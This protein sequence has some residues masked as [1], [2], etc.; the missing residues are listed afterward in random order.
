[1]T[2]TAENHTPPAPGSATRVAIAGLT[3]AGLAHATVLATLPGCEIAGVSDPRTAPRRS[4]RGMGHAAA[5]YPRFEKLLARETPAAVIVAAPQGERAALVRAALE[6]GAAVLAEPPLAATLAEAEA[7]VALASDKG[8]KLAVSQPMCFQ[9]VFVRA[10]EAMRAGVIGAPRQA[11]ASLYLSRIFSP[12]DLRRLVGPLA[13]GV[14]AHHALD[15]IALLV[16][17]LGPPIEVKASW[18]CMHGAVEDELHAMMKLASGAEVGLDA[19]WSVPGHPRAAT[20]IEI[21]G[22]VGSLLVSDDALELDLPAPCAGFPQG[23]TRLRDG[24]LPQPARFDL[25]GESRW[26]EDNAFVA[27]LA[28]G[29][30]PPGEAAAALRAQRVME[31]CYASARGGGNAVRV[32]A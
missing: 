32:S 23:Q 14:I 3:R 31:A 12:R 10:R 19:S 4:L 24:D 20:V 5:A 29:P 9:P 7:L 15:L 21:Q 18:R 16:D 11:R 2:K 8:L 25:E 27:W 22:E 6:A 28:G 13:G 1:M 17:L 30:P 26:L